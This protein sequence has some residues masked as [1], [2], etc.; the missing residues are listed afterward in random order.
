MN[1][2]V[3][4]A[5]CDASKRTINKLFRMHDESQKWPICSRFNATERAIRR[6]KGQYMHGGFE[7]ALALDAEISSIVNNHIG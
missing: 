4:Y 7:Y 1:K 2:N 6:L 3:F 5:S